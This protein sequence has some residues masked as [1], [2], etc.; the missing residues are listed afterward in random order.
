MSNIHI[1]KSESEQNI[2]LN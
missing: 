1:G 2:M